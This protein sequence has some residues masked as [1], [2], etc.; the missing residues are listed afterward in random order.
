MKDP[1][2]VAEA[3]KTRL[4]VDPVGGAEIDRLL[5]EIYAT[6]KDVIEK[7]RAAIRN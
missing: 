3:L 4:E 2:F 5:A 1:D 6:P 7:A